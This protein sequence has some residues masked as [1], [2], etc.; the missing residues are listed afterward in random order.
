M[1]GPN[2]GSALEAL[3]ENHRAFLSYLERRVGDHALAEDILQDAFAKVVARPEQAPLMKESSLGFTARCAMRRSISSGA[4]ERLTART[5]HSRANSKRM[6]PL[7]T[8]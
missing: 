8:R 1:D 4:A 3:L 6:S 7:R 5:R 2:T